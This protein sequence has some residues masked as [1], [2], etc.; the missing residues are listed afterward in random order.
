MPWPRTLSGGQ[1]QRLAIARAIVNRPKI[2]FAD[3]PTG[4]LD[5]ATGE[6]VINLLFGLN[7]KLKWGVGF[8]I[9]CKHSN[10]SVH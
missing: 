7:K 1:K 4:N 5:S 9:A 10:N 6:L 3:E 8:F 2:I